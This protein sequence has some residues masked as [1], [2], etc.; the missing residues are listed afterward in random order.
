MAMVVVGA[1][2]AAVPAAQA[3]PSCSPANAVPGGD[4]PVYGG[5][6]PSTR[7]QG[8]ETA[9]TPARAAQLAPAWT[10]NS[11]SL[12]DSSGGF[13][14]TPV[15]ADGCVFAASVSG[16]VYALDEATGALV[17]E[18]DF[19]SAPAGTGGMFVGAPAV[20]GG[21]VLLL[22]D[23]QDAPYAAALDERT[24]SVLWRSA[25]VGH[26][27]GSYTNAAAAVYDGLLFFGYSAA[28]GDSHGQGGWALIDTD[29]GAIVKQVDTIP[30]AD[31]AAGYAGGSVWA[32]PAIDTRTGYAYV[33]TGNPDS[34]TLEHRY[35]NAI[36]KI[37]LDR[38]R[39][40]TFGQVVASYKGNP[41]QYTEELQALS[42]TPACAA[43]ETNQ[44]WPLDDP[45]CGQLDL[46]FGASPSLFR[47]AS[48]RLLVGELQKSG[49]FH[50]ARAS[51]MAAAWHAL[52]GLSCALCNAA[53]TAFDGSAVA[54]VG[55]P[56]GVFFSLA[57]ATGASRWSQPLADGVH[58]ESTSSAA[59]VDYTVDS[60]GFLDA[61]DAATG[62]SVLKRSV[63][64]DAGTPVAPIASNGIAIAGHTVFVAAAAAPNASGGVIV[65]YR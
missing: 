31:Q 15:V 22:V 6:A 17:W 30:P 49:V 14:S 36:V 63:A 1:W 38:S 27:A 50:A 37:D 29:T 33:G 57:P 18:R 47:D 9:L 45:V 62:A 25:P 20:A 53:S 11:A 44:T 2:L 41:D 23:Q 19:P 40:L 64:A 26:G 54:G 34:K 42:Q 10:F 52:V 35:T 13:E 8:A 24:G 56:G 55:T 58:Y 16:R 46:D 48:G 65:A 60:L 4:W 51:D 59:G 32:T 43:S 12:G 7:N 28:E 5:N 21:K 3:A 61:F 39:P